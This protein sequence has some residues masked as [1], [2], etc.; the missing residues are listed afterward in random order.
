[1]SDFK[2]LRELIA[3]ATAAG[4]ATQKAIAEYDAAVADPTVEDEDD[5]TETD[6]IET[7]T[8]EAGGVLAE[9]SALL[10]GLEEGEKS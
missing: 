2:K 4:D 8:N 6:A 10:D 1:M 9:L 7:L 3:S 5:R